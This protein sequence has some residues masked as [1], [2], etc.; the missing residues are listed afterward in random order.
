MVFD[1]VAV[2]NPLEVILFDGVT[3]ENPL[4]PAVTEMAVEEAKLVRS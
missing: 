2:A 1:G 4:D 3:V